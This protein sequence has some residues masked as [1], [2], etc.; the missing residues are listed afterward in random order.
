MAANASGFDAQFNLG[1][2]S[3]QSYTADS[4]ATAITGTS[5]TLT[6]T[7]AA[8]GPVGNTQQPTITRAK[9]WLSIS[10]LSAACVIGTIDVYLQDAQNTPILQY[11]DIFPA[12][13]SATAQQGSEFCG[14]IFIGQGTQMANN[15]VSVK[16]VIA[17][18]GANH[19][20]TAQLRVVGTP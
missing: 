13:A 1:G 4:T 8:V 16:A 7:F 12:S 11:C 9:Y 17:L 2:T 18:S 3:A 20:A 15:I 14:E 19:T 5:Q 6:A 10:N